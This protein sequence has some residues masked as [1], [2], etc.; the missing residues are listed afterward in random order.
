METEVGWK[1]KFGQGSNFRLVKM[2]MVVRIQAIPQAKGWL[3]TFENWWQSVDSPCRQNGGRLPPLQL[4]GDY[5]IGALQGALA[6]HITFI[7]VPFTSRW[8]NFW[9]KR[10]IPSYFHPSSKQAWSNL[11]QPTLKHVELSLL[12]CYVTSSLKGFSPNPRWPSADEWCLAWALRW[13]RG[14]SN[15]RHLIASW[16]Q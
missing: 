5:P 9:M 8:M 11:S 2:M 1:L 12:C 10:I 13:P 16:R 14:S 15:P 7:T 6:T 4:S 3:C